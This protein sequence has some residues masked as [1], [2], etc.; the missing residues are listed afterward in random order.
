MS[1]WSMPPVSQETTVTLCRWQVFRI[2]M[3]EEHWD[4]LRGWD[5]ANCCG[6]CSTPIIEFD[7]ANRRVVT[8]SGRVYVL[9]G[10][11]GP[12][13]DAAYVFHSRFGAGPPAGVRFDDVSTHYTCPPKE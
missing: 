8:R 12:D 4:F 2:S 11:S 13:E 5:V 7:P 10:E 3:G 6:R 1:T 9:E